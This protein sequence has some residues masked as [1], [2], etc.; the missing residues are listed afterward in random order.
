LLAALVGAI[1]LAAGA[2]S[3]AQDKRD[4]PAKKAADDAG[5]SI[6]DTKKNLLSEA[7]Q[8]AIKEGNFLRIKEG[9]DK[10]SIAQ[11][12]DITFPDDWVKK[13]AQ[14]DKQ[15]QPLTKEEKKILDALSKPMDVE[16]KDSTL[17]D[18]IKYLQDKAGVNIVVP[19]AILEEKNITYKVP[20]SVN[21]KGV[22]LRTILKKTLAD[23]GLVYIVKDNVIQ[24]TTEERAQKTLTTR[25]Y[26][27][28]DMMLLTDVHV[29]RFAQQAQ[30]IRTINDIIGVIVGTV[31][32][33]SWW[34]NGGPGRIVFD[35][36]H[37]TLIVTQTAE[38]HYMMGLG[39]K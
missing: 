22:T 13:M 34:V 27:M 32:P 25:T 15:Q 23:V 7:E 24:V 39:K 16:L 2:S 26:Y 9:E 35:P 14:R 11:A 12:K 30:A 33:D 18:V 38:V 4:D 3:R 8:K 17:E 29:P 1:I 36:T 31:E 21:L 10:I 5:K 28:G 6:K 19:Q 37:M 20:V